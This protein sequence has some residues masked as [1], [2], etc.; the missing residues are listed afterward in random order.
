MES[1]EKHSLLD[2]IQRKILKE[3]TSFSTQRILEATG[4]ESIQEEMG[5]GLSG[6]FNM[7]DEML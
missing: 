6:Q 2:D 5:A 4:G 7:G 3:T 1:S